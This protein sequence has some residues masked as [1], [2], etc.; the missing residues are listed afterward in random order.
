MAGSTREPHSARE[1]RARLLRADR[2]ATLRLRIRARQLHCTGATRRRRSSRLANARAA[3]TF[4]AP[5]ALIPQRA[6][7]GARVG[8]V[9]PLLRSNPNP[10]PQLLIA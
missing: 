10:V 7:L 5:L 4:A 2:L 9:E 8:V 6:Q 1:A 3:T